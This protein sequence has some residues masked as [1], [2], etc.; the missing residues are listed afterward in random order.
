MGGGNMARTR[1]LNLSKAKEQNDITLMEILYKYGPITRHQIANMMGLSIPTITTNIAEMMKNGVVVEV[2][3]GEDNT[4]GRKARPVDLCSIY[5]YFLGVEIT[6]VRCTFC[7]TDLRFQNLEMKEEYRDNSDYDE[8]MSYVIRMIQSIL[9]A[10]E[11]IR[12]KIAGIGVGLPGFI[13]SKKGVLRSLGRLNWYHKP[14]KEELEKQ[15][16]LPVCVENNGRVRVI[17]E[18]IINGSIRPDTFA[19]LFVSLGIA[20]PLLIKDSILTGYSAGAGE[21]GHM[22]LKED[23]PECDMC[24]K[25]GCLDSLASEVAIVKS[26]QKALDDGKAAILKQHVESNGRLTMHEIIRAQS[27]GDREVNRIVDEAVRY[28]GLAVANMANFISPNLIIVDAYAMKLK[29]NRQLFMKIVKEY[30]YG[31]NEDEIAIEF[32]EYDKFAGCKGAAAYAIRHF[33]I[34]GKR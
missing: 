16:G 6:P 3:G 21:I 8:M 28:L 20:C 33:F 15:L 19:Y 29:S 26:C 12:D 31:F 9:A 23:G 22:I 2:A 34:Q 7:L 18:D 4:V 32:K 25:R 10:H 5:Q 17:G 14:I 11:S 13:E 27:D 30:L 1:G 24:G